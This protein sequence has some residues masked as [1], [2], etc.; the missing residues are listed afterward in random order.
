MSYVIF[1]FLSAFCYGVG[2]II[3]K[4]ILKKGVNPITATAFGTIFSTG[5][6]FL[7][8]W[9]K[10]I[11]PTK[12][13]IASNINIFIMISFFGM[14]MVMGTTFA[15]IAMSYPEGKVAVVN[16]MSLA[17]SIVIATVLAFL[18]LGESLSLKMILGLILV[19]SGIMLLF[20]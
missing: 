2:Q 15:N 10:G 20:F 8:C 18:F 9:I 7:I 17:G 12:V 3:M 4:M 13:L 19:S 6:T 1:A 16:I 11:L 5:L 14:I